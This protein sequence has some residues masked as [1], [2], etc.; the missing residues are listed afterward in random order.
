MT[1]LQVT[2]LVAIA[3]AI[4][5]AMA[6]L[7]SEDRGLLLPTRVTEATGTVV[8]PGFLGLMV[9]GAVAAVMSWG[10]YGPLAQENL[11]GGPDDGPRGGYGITLGAFT[12]A[13]LIGVGG[14]KWLTSQ[15]DK[16]LLRQAAVAAARG[17]ANSDTADRIDQAQP[18][19]ALHLARSL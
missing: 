9:V 16:T 14:P 15:V 2:G 10:L 8:R 19:E 11:A 5:G 17:E 6:A 1:V 4:G 18:T 3:G 12:G 13:V 7:L